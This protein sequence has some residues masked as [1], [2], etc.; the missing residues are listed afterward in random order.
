MG[1]CYNQLR[2]C[3]NPH[4]FV[5]GSLQ[6]ASKTKTFQETSRKSPKAFQEAS[7]KPQ[8]PIQ[9]ASTKTSKLL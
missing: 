6:Q 5:P 2:R 9:E 7:R 4:I 8:K 1:L 3:Q